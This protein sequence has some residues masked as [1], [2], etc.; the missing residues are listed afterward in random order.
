MAGK[1]KHLKRSQTAPA[2]AARRRT[3][4]ATLVPLMLF[5]AAVL[6]GVGGTILW[7]VWGRLPE[8]QMIRVGW[9]ARERALR[10]AR[11]TFT[12][13]ARE[14]L[15]LSAMSNN[16]A[17]S[18]HEPGELQALRQASYA[19]ATSL[20]QTELGRLLL[21]ALVMRRMELDHTP[22]EQWWARLEPYLA[23]LEHQTFDHYIPDALD[24]LEP[25]LQRIGLSPG[26]ARQDALNLVAYE[27]GPFLQYFVA[28]L[29]EVAAVARAAGNETAAATCEH[30]ARRLLRDWIVAPGPA[31]LRLLAADLLANQLTSAAVTSSA[32][33]APS[34]PATANVIR[35]CRAW[36][37]AYRQQAA[38]L[39][40]PPTPLRL[41]DEP[42]AGPT[43]A[44]LQQHFILGWWLLAGIVAIAPLAILA[45]LLSLAITNPVRPGWGAI[46]LA[47][48]PTLAFIVAGWI[49]CSTAA[50]FA[51]EELLRA[52]SDH[53]HVRLPYIAAIAVLAAAVLGT[54]SLAR[55]LR[56]APRWRPSGAFVCGLTW[57][58][59]ATLLVP[60]ALAIERDRRAY[61][62]A[63][64]A[65][66]EQR[67]NNLADPGALLAALRAWKP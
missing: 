67:T 59:L 35:A 49:A 30:L 15:A 40:L 21:A 33:S 11:Q 23:G 17:R 55:T 3:R 65:P 46:L 39:P 45:Y 56:D 22:V 66:L 42:L 36:R 6:S 62:E 7:R 13:S 48:A 54:A 2:A 37:E 58:V 51:Y 25:A 20:R 57:L 29:G 1:A 47:V 10:D 4:G 41:N 5:V 8:Q 52:S 32:P 27:H 19:D 26:T 50:Q 60:A 16:F 18:L 38:A 64:A 63:L 9:D 12:E 34:D 31:S 43:A 53:M 28:R 14:S 24:A 61:D 44:R